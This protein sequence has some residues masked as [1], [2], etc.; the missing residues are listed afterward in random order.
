M[1]KIWDVIPGKPKPVATFC[2]S[3]FS[4]IYLVLIIY[5]I[6]LCVVLYISPIVIRQHM[7]DMVYTDQE[8]DI[9][10]YMNLNFLVEKYKS[11]KNI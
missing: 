5:V 4:I 2:E 6:Y 3:L 1:L 9:E 7:S 11:K 10:N 8:L